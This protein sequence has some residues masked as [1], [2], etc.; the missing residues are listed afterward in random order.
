M[1]GPN[2]AR[3]GFTLIELMIVASVLAIIVSIGAPLYSS[4][5][6]TARVTKA[7]AELRTISTAVDQFRSVRGGELPLTLYQVG[8]GGRRDPWGVPY[9][10]LNYAAGTGD[11]LDWAIAAGLVDP[12][13]FSAPAAPGKSGGKGGDSGIG[14]SVADVANTLSGSEL[15]AFIQDLKSGSASVSVG[16]PVETTRRRDKYMFPLNTDYDLFSLGPDART[17][18]SLAHPASLD[19]VIRAN[20]GGFFGVAGT[21]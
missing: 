14:G 4:G 13:D 8:Y 20:D 2:G 9:C 11:G 21:Y 15:A 1:R 19:D 10:Y 6:R 12:T 3:R 16:V 7:I 17:S 5:L 18:A